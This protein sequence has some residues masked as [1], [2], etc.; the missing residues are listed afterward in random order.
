MAVQRL[1]VVLDSPTR[2]AVKQLAKESKV[3]MSSVGRDLI[4]EALEVYED[5]C[6]D[7]IAFQREKGFNWKKSLT[8]HKVWGK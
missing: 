8:H 6:L 3:S 5:R 2:D 1:L 4:K 7:K